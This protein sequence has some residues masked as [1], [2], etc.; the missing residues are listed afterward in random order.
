M[1][2]TRSLS[3]FLRNTRTEINRLG[4]DGTPIRLERRE[5]PVATVLPPTAIA[6]YRNQLLRTARIIAASD[7]QPD[8]LEDLLETL[9]CLTDHI[10]PIHDA[11]GHPLPG[12]RARE[13]IRSCVTD[14]MSWESLQSRI[15]DAVNADPGAHLNEPM[16]FYLDADAARDRAAGTVVGFGIAWQEA[17]TWGLPRTEARRVAALWKISLT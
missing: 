17:L 12:D 3:A 16:P 5:V 11:D 10:E 4:L 6:D 13:R 7:D 2:R 14:G 1:Q 15:E 8:R 9:G